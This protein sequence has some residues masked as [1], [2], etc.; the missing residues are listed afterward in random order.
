MTTAN[1]T[2]VEAPLNPG[3]ARHPITVREYVRMGEA[4]VLGPDVRCELI[5]G[6]IIDMSPIGPPHASTTNRLAELLFD[7]VGGKAIVSAQNP[8]VLGDLSAPQPD[9][10]LLRHRDDYYAQ[11]HPGPADILLLIEVADTSL[12]YDRDTKLPLYARFQVPEVWI[13]D[14]AGRHLDMHREPEGTRYTHQ[15]R[16]SDLSRIE[17]AALPGLVLDLRGL[18]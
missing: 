12:A 14:I 6:E 1:A 18:F 3:P 17:V 2:R 4:R 16:A 5:E 11:A 8:V 9:L 15:F 10:A 13:V 7:A